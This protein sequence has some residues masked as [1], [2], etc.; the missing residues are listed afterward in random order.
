M[1]DA[2]KWI[3]LEEAELPDGYEIV[4]KDE[5][6]QM[7]GVPGVKLQM[8]DGTWRNRDRPEAKLTSFFTYARPIRRARMSPYEID[9]LSLPATLQ[10]SLHSPIAKEI[11]ANLVLVGDAEAWPVDD[12]RSRERD[13]G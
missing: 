8:V 13:D 5:Y 11:V 12:E 1:A 10:V 6:E 3:T 7:V 4:P 9:A 2:T